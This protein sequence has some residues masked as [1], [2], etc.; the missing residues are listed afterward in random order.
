MILINWVQ[1]LPYVLLYLLN[2]WF[3]HVFNIEVPL[4]LSLSLISYYALCSFLKFCVNFYVFFFFF[5]GLR[6][7]EHLL[8]LQTKG[9]QHLV[10]RPGYDL[11]TVSDFEPLR[12]GTSLSLLCFFFFFLAQE[13]RYLSL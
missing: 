6:K 8:S 5:F 13:M 4:S 3:V 9:G 1:V 11:Q 2:Q 12:F 10:L 7:A